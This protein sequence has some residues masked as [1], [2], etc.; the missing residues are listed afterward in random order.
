MKPSGVF[1]EWTGLRFF[2]TIFRF[3]QNNG[4]EFSPFPP[5]AMFKVYYLSSKPLF[6][7]PRLSIRGIGIRE[8][9]PPCYV[10]RPQGTGD[11]LFMIFHDPVRFGENA[12]VLY[13][14]G[15]IV[16]WDRGAS[17]F[18]GNPLFRWSHSW[19]HCDGKDIGEALRATRIPCGQPIVLSNPSHADKYLFDIHE[20][21]TGP[22][23][24]NRVI[25]RNTLEN[26][27]QEASRPRPGRAPIPDALLAAQ[28]TLDTRY[29]ERLTLD[30]LA[31][32]A[33]LS[34]PHFCTE[35]RRHFG[36]PPIA[37]LLQ[38]RMRV[39]AMLLRGTALSVGEVGR[40]VG[41]DDPYYFS[42]LF[43]ANFGMPPSRLTKA[44]RYPFV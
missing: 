2:Y 28:Q 35:F 10:K 14:A 41:Y 7:T 33:G 34:L 24:P 12:E 16:L 30:Q 37:Y 19:I 5:Q 42:K 31:S 1:W 23:K 21:L 38:R 17:H 11:Y 6:R 13:A 27:I 4:A 32:E 8:V 9:M 20:E 15:T 3:C 40:R 22:L 18:Y 43:K 36:A 29:D 25:L 39:A 44:N 26:L